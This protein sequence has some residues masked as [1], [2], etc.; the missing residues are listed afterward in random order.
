[1][2]AMTNKFSFGFLPFVIV[3]LTIACESEKRIPPKGYIPVTP[4]STEMLEAAYFW[5]PQDQL[6]SSYWK[7]APYIE[8][9]LSNGSIKNLY[10]DGYLNMTGTYDGL[11][12]FNNGIDPKVTLKAGYDDEYLYVL[13]EWKDTTADASIASKLYVGPD[14]PL[15]TDSAGGWTSQRNQDNLALLFNMQG[16]DYDV[17]KWSMAYTAPLNMALNTSADNSGKISDDTQILSVNSMD[18]SSRSKPSYEWNGERQ[19]I[20]L[21]DGTR[22]LLD[23][24]YYLLDEMKMNFVGDIE[25]GHKA[26]N[27][28]DYDRINKR[29]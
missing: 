4:E 27:E 10:P 29:R 26:F 7:D 2:F 16:G 8:V 25:K 5:V 15:K 24:A 28:N 3:V 13:V 17:W 9:T 21:V 11:A 6:K 22:R 19:E 12:D 1:M 14:D 18:G 23:P 20:T